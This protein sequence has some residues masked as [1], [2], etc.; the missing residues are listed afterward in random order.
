MSI[1]E[2]DSEDYTFAGLMDMR[3]RYAAILSSGEIPQSE[4][5]ITMKYYLET[6]K[7]YDD[8][9]LKFETIEGIQIAIEFIDEI[10]KRKIRNN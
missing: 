2:H 6:G 8:E 3:N 4:I 9:K 1:K 7:A 10:I 5:D